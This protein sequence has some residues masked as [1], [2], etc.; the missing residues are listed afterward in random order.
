LIFSTTLVI[1]LIKKYASTI[2]CYIVL[3]YCRHFKLDLPYV[4]AITFFN[5]MNN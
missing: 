5:K 2:F 3:Y 1:C 4:F